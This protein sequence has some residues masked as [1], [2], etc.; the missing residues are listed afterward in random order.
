MLNRYQIIGHLGQNANVKTTESGSTAISF[1]VAVTESYKDKQGQKVENTTWVN[2][3]IWRQKDQSTKIAEYLT[4]GTKVLVEGKL[5]ARAYSD[6]QGEAK[7]SLELKVDNVQLLGAKGD[8]T[9]TTT[10]HPATDYS[11]HGYGQPKE[12]TQE[13]VNNPF[14]QSTDDSDLPF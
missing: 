10:E 4:K 12:R 7:A 14:T 3:T 11:A 1:S 6:K 5:T 8:N 2:C 9:S 13:E